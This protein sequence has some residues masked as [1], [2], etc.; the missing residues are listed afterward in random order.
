MGRKLARQF[1]WKV[2]DTV[3]LRG[4]I[5]PGTW[6]FTIRGIYEGKDARTDEQQ[7]FIH[8]KRL[9]ESIR[10]RNS[11]AQ[12]DYVGVFV[13]GIRNPDEAPQVSRAIDGMFRNS[14]A[15]TLTET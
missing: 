12:A 15:E 3:A 13:V 8:W 7:M 11:G 2:G 4:T 1:G 6:S 14:L 9:A 10:A 5:Y